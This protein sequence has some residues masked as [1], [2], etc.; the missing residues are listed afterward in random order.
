MRSYAIG[1]WSICCLCLCVTGCQD[2][3][4][5]ETDTTTVE[6]DSSM[7]PA[8]SASATA[9]ADNSDDE[10][11]LDEMSYKELLDESTKVNEDER[12][13]LVAKLIEKIKENPSSPDY[14]KSLP[15]LARLAGPDA[16]EILDL[17]LEHH[18]DSP[19]FASVLQAATR[20]PNGTAFLERVATSAKDDVTRHTAMFWHA[21]ILQNQEGELDLLRQVASFD[22]DIRLG[23]RNLKAMAAR[24]IVTI[25]IQERLKVG[26]EAPEIVGKDVHGEEFKLSDYRGKVV[27]LD[28]WGDW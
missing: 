8:S 27:L 19:Q 12:G 15:T 6:S 1:L 10:L 5:P 9:S 26:K 24:R 14:V 23:A 7:A 13:P 25:E 22:G 4:T 21:Q 2:T 17:A 18:S 11:S 28:F 16:T 20:M 3:S